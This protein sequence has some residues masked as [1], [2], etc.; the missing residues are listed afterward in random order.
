M[1]LL[2]AKPALLCVDIER[3]PI[4]LCACDTTI[5][6]FQIIFPKKKYNSVFF[7]VVDMVWR[8]AM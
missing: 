4:Y 1:N 8:R 5:V 2:C 3:K 7:Y 6:Y